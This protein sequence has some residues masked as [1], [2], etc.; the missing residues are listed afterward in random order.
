MTDEEDDYAGSLLVAISDS[1]IL[2][3]Q[4]WAL[5]TTNGLILAERRGRSSP[6]ETLVA[7]AF[8]RDLPIR[9]DSGTFEGAWNDTL[10]IARSRRLTT[11]DA[12]YLELALRSGRALATLDVKLK[13]AATAEGV[14]LA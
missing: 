5:E 14:Q 1:A 3:P 10:S 4:H 8:I 6:E 9:V 11:Y 2:V 7:L 12:A 13:Q